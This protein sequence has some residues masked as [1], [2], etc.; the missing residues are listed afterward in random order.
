[1]TGL[2]R[3]VSVFIADR[4]DKARRI[5]AL[6]ATHFGRRPSGLRI[7]DIGCGNGDIS[8]YLSTAN[9]QYAVDVQDRRRPANRSFEYRPVDSERLPFEDGFFDAVISNHVIE[10]VP[11]QPLHLREIHRVLRRGGVAYLATPNRSSPFMRGHAGNTLV[12]RYARM[13]P[14]F[15]QAGFRVREVSVECLKQPAYLTGPRFLR[16]VP[17]WVLRGLRGLYPSHIFLLVPD[18]CQ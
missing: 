18:A 5:E 7:L 2:Q 8:E 10:H 4:G 11:D 13:K 3:R 12:L 1:M 9:D 6:L 16:L 15:E 17:A 14:I